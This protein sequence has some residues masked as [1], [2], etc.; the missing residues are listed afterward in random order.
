MKDST[1]LQDAAAGRRGIAA[2]LIEF[3]LKRPWPALVASTAAVLI[4]APGLLFL[5]LRTDGQALIPP[6]DPAVIEDAEIRAHFGLTDP[7]AIVVETDHPEGI[8]HTETL[9]RVRDLT[10]EIGALDWV[11]PQS[12]RSLAT[13]KRDRVYPGT[14]NFRPYLDPLPDT[15]ELIQQFREDLEA[16]EILFG[17]LVG[18]EARS[19]AI[20]VGSP[21][22]LADVDHARVYA[23]IREIARRH[24][25]ATDRVAVVGA[26]VAEALLGIHILED[27]SYL[28]PLSILTI[29]LILMIGCRRLWGVALG[30][31]EIV[32]CLV[33]T[34]GL[35]G[36]FGVPVYLTTAV[37]PVIL[38]TIGLADE[39]HV[40]WR[41]QQILAESP[42]RQEPLR[43]L[44]AEMRR[45]VVLTSLTTAIG[46]L[47]FLSSPLAAVR[48]FGI[49]ASVGIIFCMLWSLIAVPA[50]LKLLGPNRMRRSYRQGEAGRWIQG[51][52]TPLFRKPGIS[53]AAVGAAS[54]L[55]AAGLQWIVVQ[56]SWIDG[57]ARSS[58]FRQETDRVNAAFHGTHLLLV[59]VE[60]DPLDVKLERIFYG[61]QGPLLMPDKL[62]R[63]ADFEAFIKNMPHVGGVL[64][65]A[66]QLIMA[67]YLWR[68][69]RAEFKRLPGHPT[70]TDRVLNAWGEGSGEHRRRE[71]ID[72]ARKRAIVTI[73]LKDANYRHTAQ[74]MAS[75]RDYA[76]KNLA[77]EGMQTAFAGDVAVSQAMIPAIVR[78]QVL[79][80]LL[81]LLG[82]FAAV[83][84]L[85]LSLKIGAAT[86]APACLAVLWTFG[87]MGWLSVPLGVATSMFC[88]ITLGIGV[89]YSIHFWESRRRARQRFPEAQPWETSSRAAREAGPAIV[90]D[91]LAIAC[92][93]GLLS[94]SQVPANARLGLLVA[95]A[96]V[97]NC[98]LTLGGLGAWLCLSRRRVERS[99]STAAET[100]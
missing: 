89:D 80:L 46:F 29:C 44:F 78:T 3:A 56:D 65:P 6:E 47:S 28:L 54:L 95:F 55:A 64:G 27:L 70:E 67:S 100:A 83:S 25:S 59:H 36:W 49:F 97:A 58:Q 5:Q 23:E 22:A 24:E 42:A 8:Y 84:L 66:E 14:L 53:L 72:D 79:S 71:V 82:A 2:R 60:S 86:L 52:L 17:T 81:A 35:M 12:I 69:R 87:G 68:A 88:A 33:F 4:A 77:P 7:I 26:P 31:G 75:I 90:A 39:I 13:E 50:C 85:H 61:D 96:L 92:G 34:F 10:L 74:I 93:F 76:A 48:A 21:P 62:K 15:P 16:A 32:A 9:R 40:F 94:F 38:T 98:I 73:F 18:K 99:A 45:P 63:I 20:L 1:P 19:T 91:T 37:L 11:D 57:F 51:A 30:M 43:A 41:Y